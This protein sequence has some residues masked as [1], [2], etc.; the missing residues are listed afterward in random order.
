MQVLNLQRQLHTS[1]LGIAF[2][3]RDHAT[4]DQQESLFA[5]YQAGGLHTK[6]SAKQLRARG[7]G[8]R[9]LEV[10][11]SLSGLWSRLWRAKMCKRS[12]SR[13]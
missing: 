5:M 12:S 6:P 2:V 1:L 9:T 10:C 11:L 13:G 3:L 8:R 7:I 4:Q